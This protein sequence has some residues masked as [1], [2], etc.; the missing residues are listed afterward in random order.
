MAVIPL[1]QGVIFTPGRKP[2]IPCQVNDLGGTISISALM[3]LITICGTAPKTRIDCYFYK[4][5][6]SD[7]GAD[8]ERLKSIP[9]KLKS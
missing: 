3:R 5:V 9:A 7:E 6:G 2:L 1:R 4:L 8:H